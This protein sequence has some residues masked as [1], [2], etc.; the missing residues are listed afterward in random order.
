AAALRRLHERVS[1]YHLGLRARAGARRARSFW[2]AGRLRRAAVAPGLHRLRRTHRADDAGARFLPA[3]LRAF[4]PCPGRRALYAGS[5]GRLVPECRGAAQ[6]TARDPSL[7]DP[8]DRLNGRVAAEHRPWPRIEVQADIWTEAADRL[9]HGILD[10]LGLWGE[11]QA[12]HMAVADASD[13]N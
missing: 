13:P 9:S 11:P 4:E 7:P 10:L 3:D 12:V 6:M 1:G 8:F 2:T 5:H